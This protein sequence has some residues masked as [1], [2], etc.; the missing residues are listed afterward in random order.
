MH[1]KFRELFKIY[2][3]I[4][5]KLVERKKEQPSK[6]KRKKT[7]KTKNKKTRHLKENMQEVVEYRMSATKRSQCANIQCTII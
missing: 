1:K 2:E 4:R 6:K 5:G 3:K 7:K